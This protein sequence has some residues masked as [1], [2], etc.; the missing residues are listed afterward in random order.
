MELPRLHWNSIRTRVTLATVAVFLVCIGLLA[1][2]A[3]QRLRT[4]LERLLAEQQLSVATR[5]AL[6]VD[7]DL[8]ERLRTLEILAHG[9]EE[10][11]SEG[12]AALHAYLERHVQFL[13]QFPL[14]AYVCGLDGVIVAELPRG[15]HRIG[16]NVSTRPHMVSTLRDGKASISDPFIGKVSDQPLIAMSVPIV[17]SDGKPMGALAGVVDLSKPNF[18]DAIG[19]TPYGNGGGYLL[20]SPRQ[21][22]IVTSSDKRQIMQHLPAV[23]AN[24]MIDRFV[25]GYEGTGFLVNTLG[26]PVMSSVKTIPTTGW[27]VAVTL[28]TEEA[29]APIVALQRGVVTSAAVLSVLAL[30][31]VWWLIGRE[32]APLSRAAQKLSSQPAFAETLQPIASNGAVEV[33][34]MIDALNVQIEARIR[35]EAQLKASEAHLHSVIDATPVP[36]AINDAKGNISY[37]NPAFV[38]TFGYTL[39][40]IPTLEHWWP[41]AYPDA[42]YRQSI[43]FRWA[44][45][46]ALAESTGELFVPMEIQIRSKDGTVRDVLASASYLPE[47]ANQENLV[48]LLDVSESVHTNR[49]LKNS[50]QER[51]ALL[52]EVHHRV[53]NNLQVITSLLRLEGSRSAD[54][55][56]KSMLADM[57]GRIRSMALLHESLY[58]A[59]TYA[60]VDLSTYLAQLCTQVFR[61]QQTRAGAVVL[62]LQLDKVFVGLD[63]ATPCGLLANEIISNSFKHGFPDGRSGQVLVELHALEGGP[64][65]CLRFSDDGVGLPPDF[66]TRR[67]SSLGLQLVG[68]LS[69]QMGGT[70]EV[71]PGPATVLAI[72]FTPE[73]PVPASQQTHAE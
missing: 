17:G 45:A 18:L 30:V 11:M 60:S 65:W 67:Q 38:R 57:Q 8:R 42:D 73:K 27:Y 22:L 70:L 58:R 5:T 12:S 46:L 69:K 20:V 54:A 49:E 23:G 4:D 71:G 32:L 48:I 50:L 72:V 55:T 47:S 52:K 43:V 66:D 56:V 10:P 53:K 7:D 9:I 29:F 33:S 6:Q 19:S 24:P 13:K 40:D 28:P 3:N 1:S 2:Y 21:R 41:L 62:K 15:S 31:L 34:K 14:G 68:D 51:E 61:S 59:G 63:Q 64:S 25:Q 36:L 35:R 16:V 39:T 44:A 26:V 37:L